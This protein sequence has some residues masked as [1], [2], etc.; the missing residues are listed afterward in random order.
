MADPAGE[1]GKA[2]WLAALRSDSPPWPVRAMLVGEVL[3]YVAIALL[4]TLVGMRRPREVNAW[5]VAFFVFAAV[6]PIAMNLLHGDRPKDSGLRLDT[7]RPSLKEVLPTMLVMMLGVGLVGWWAGGW[8]W[9]HGE[10]FARMGSQYM[11][12]G[13]IQQYLLQAFGL[14]RFRQ[15]GLP[16]WAAVAGAAGVFAIMH[17]PNWPLV[18][19]TFG[20]GLVWCVQFLRHPNLLTLGLAHGVLAVWVYHVL[21]GEWMQR[22]TIGAEY[23]H[24]LAR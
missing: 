18:A 22:L 20:A 13:P 12:W 19:L 8:H 16:A 17:A 6:W 5:V 24:R 7:F 10:H 4:Y 15:A 2:D 9:H 14:R 23:L 11:L 3:G 21:P 1:S